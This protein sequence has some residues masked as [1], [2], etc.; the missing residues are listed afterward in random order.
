MSN[1]TGPCSH[2]NQMSTCITC[3]QQRADMLEVYRRT[4]FEINIK[5]AT[6]WPVSQDYLVGMS[7][8]CIQNAEQ[9]IEADD[10]LLVGEE[11]KPPKH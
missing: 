8:M 3:L 2:G 6:E 10:P 1:N 4:M 7:G 5:C 9:I 11:E